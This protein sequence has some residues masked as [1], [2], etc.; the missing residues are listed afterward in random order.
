MLIVPLFQQQK[1]SGNKA[2]HTTGNVISVIQWLYNKRLYLFAVLLITALILGSSMLNA[3]STVGLQT[4]PKL[5]T[6]VNSAKNTSMELKTSS[7]NNNGAMSQPEIHTNISVHSN[8]LTSPTTHSSGVDSKSIS[9]SVTINGQTTP[10][11]S[12]STTLNL[13]NNNDQTSVNVQIN[14]N[15]SSSIQS[16]TNTY[17]SINGNSTSNLNLNS[18]VSTVA[19]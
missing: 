3:M 15:S 12:P 5:N 7:Q 10:L 13:S 16:Q 4:I 11:T 1:L 6:N 19:E 14:G 18:N 17:T 9:G 2:L 8:N